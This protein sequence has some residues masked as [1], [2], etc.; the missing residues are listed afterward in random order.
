MDT[1]RIKHTASQLIEEVA[2]FIE[3]VESKDLTNEQWFLNFL[4]ELNELSIKH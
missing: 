2:S 4:D 3:L 1:N